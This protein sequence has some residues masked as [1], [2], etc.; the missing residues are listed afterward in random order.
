M[1]IIFQDSLCAIDLTKVMRSCKL[2]PFVIQILKIHENNIQR[3]SF[4]II[5]TRLLLC[6]KH[7]WQARICVSKRQLPKLNVTSHQRSISSNATCPSQSNW[8]C[9][10][11]CLHFWTKAHRKSTIC[12]YLER[13]KGTLENVLRQLN[14]LA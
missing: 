14:A 10:S 8:R 9:C 1:L 5:F 2:F 4:N 13:K 7:S 12:I 6:M 3:N 11:S